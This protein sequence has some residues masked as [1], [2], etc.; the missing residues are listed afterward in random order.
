MNV[1]LFKEKE[2]ALDFFKQRVYHAFEN[3]INMKDTKTIDKILEAIILN[4]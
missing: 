4:Q 3:V 1:E 2:K